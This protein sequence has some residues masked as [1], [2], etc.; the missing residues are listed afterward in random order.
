MFSK[1]SLPR[2]NT[3]NFAVNDRCYDPTNTNTLYLP[4]SYNN[5]TNT[6]QWNSSSINADTAL[7]MPFIH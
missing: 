4:S 7:G 6:T 2:I 1:S 3:Y 5:P